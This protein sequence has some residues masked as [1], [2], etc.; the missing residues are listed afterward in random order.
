[1]EDPKITIS[2]LLRIPLSKVEKKGKEKVVLFYEGKEIGELP[3]MII[4]GHTRYDD[5]DVI[6]NNLKWDI[7]F[8]DK[9]EEFTEM[10]SKSMKRKDISIAVGMFK[11]FYIKD[12]QNKTMATARVSFVD[13]K[14]TIDHINSVN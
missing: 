4:A 10:V 11:S 5:S 8:Q 1:M 14:W 6:V 7:I 2:I 9:Q 12:S 13:N 3:V